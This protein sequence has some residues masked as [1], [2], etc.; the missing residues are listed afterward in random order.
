MYLL[1]VYQVKEIVESFRLE[2]TLKITESNHD[3]TLLPSRKGC[4]SHVPG[5][6]VS[7]G[8]LPFEGL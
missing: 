6:V 1:D 5:E 3:L 4:P 8:R 2:E 7:A